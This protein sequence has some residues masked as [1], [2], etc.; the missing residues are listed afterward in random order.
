MTDP[1]TDEARDASAACLILARSAADSMAA[2][3]ERVLA[4][5]SAGKSCGAEEELQRRCIADSCEAAR[6]MATLVTSIDDVLIAGRGVTVSLDV[7]L[8]RL[9][10]DSVRRLMR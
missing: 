5:R 8:V 6:T 1:G 4:A 7:L 2:L 9:R 10:A 3:E